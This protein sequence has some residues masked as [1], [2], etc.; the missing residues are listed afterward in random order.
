V[1]IGEFK[2]YIRKSLLGYEYTMSERKTLKTVVSEHKV[3]FVIL[4]ILLIGG[5]VGT[6][7]IFDLLSARNPSRITL[8]T[9]TSTYD[10][11]LLDYLLPEFTKKTGIEV[12]VLSV[13]TGQA[14][15]YGESGDVD[16]ILVHSRPR[17]DAF[18]ND[19]DGQTPYGV[20]RACVMYNDF[21]IVGHENN[22]AGLLPN[23]N[24]TTVMTK[25][26]NGIDT[27]NSTFYS[28]GDGSGT[29][30]KEIYLWAAIGV[31]PDIEWF[32]EPDKYTESG[33]GMAATLQ[34]TDQDANNQGYTLIDRGTWLSFN[35]TY[36][37][38][39]ILAESV[40][41][42]DYLL[43]PYGVIPINPDLYSHVKYNSALRFVGFLT[44]DYG[45]NLINDY[46]KNGE[47]LFHADFGICKITTNCSTTEEEI[48]FWTSYQQ[49][50]D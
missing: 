17:E 38:L 31:T 45:Q 49:E 11:G 46:T 47:T 35:D 32:G 34:M 37:T 10:S 15:A 43:N 29:Y 19:S 22:P 5:S 25:L 36:T 48:A 6:Y 41:G 24:I 28:R 8:A 1:E 16:V 39:K 44:S 23:E 40:E 30:S 4:L 50:F 3:A 27:G 20:H 26:K 9:T 21:I 14:I 42:E 12:S 33:Q 2:I 7:F 13:G 18:V